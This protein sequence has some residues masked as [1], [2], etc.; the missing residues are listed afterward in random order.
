MWNLVLVRFKQVL[1]SVQDGC[2]VCEIR[3]IGSEILLDTSDGT[4]R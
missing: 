4:T 3:A 2:T 1:V